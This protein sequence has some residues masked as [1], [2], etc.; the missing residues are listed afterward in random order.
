MSVLSSNLGLTLALSSK[1]LRAKTDTAIC[2]EAAQGLVLE[3]QL[4]RSSSSYTRTHTLI[5]G[6]VTHRFGSPIVAAILVLHEHVFK[7]PAK[8]L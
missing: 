1:T 4:H 5:L 7:N 6:R 8:Q 3:K 2:T